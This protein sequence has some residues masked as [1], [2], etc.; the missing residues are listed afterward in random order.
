M[1]KI[2][3]FFAAAVCAIA[4]WAQ[5]SAVSATVK[6]QTLDVALANATD[7]FV[8]F[9]MDIVLPSGVTVLNDGTAMALNDERLTKKAGT[10][11]A[12]A[13]NANFNLVYNVIDATHVRVL[14]YNL[15]NRALDGTEGTLF[16]M[17]FAG[18][19]EGDF[20]VEGIKFVTESALAEIDLATVK[21]E[22]GADFVKG[23]VTGD[24]S[25][26]LY[27]VL[28]VIDLSLGKTN[29][30]YNLEAADTDGNGDFD[31]YDVLAIINYSL[32]K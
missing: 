6:G 29:P 19:P 15:E 10:P 32:G 4:S 27:D 22:V 24:D 26:D 14:A 8:A 16:T 11:V 21:S 17:T 18:T 23:D 3:L 25:V 20:N 5:G 28:A 31:L 12:G 13:T 9:Q 1:K 30:A 2:L 7:K